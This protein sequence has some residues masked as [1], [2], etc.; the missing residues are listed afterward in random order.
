MNML[1]SELLIVSSTSLVVKMVASI[2]RYFHVGLVAILL[3]NAI[4]LSPA[5]NIAEKMLVA[6]GSSSTLGQLAD[7]EDKKQKK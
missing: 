2:G 6:R 1:P 4:H 7:K 3:M 5:S